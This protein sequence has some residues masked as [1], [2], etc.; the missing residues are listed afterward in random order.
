MRAGVTSMPFAAKR[1]KVSALGCAISTP[2]IASGSTTMMAPPAVV[3]TTATLRRPRADRADRRAAH[4]RQRFEQGFEAFH[5]RDAAIGEERA[6]DV[7]LAGE[8]AGVRDGELAR[9]RRAAELVGDDRLAARR[10]A[11]REFAQ[12]RP[13]CGCFRGTADSCRCRGHRASRRKSRR[14]R[15]RPRCRSTRG[16]QSRCRAPCRATSARR[17]WCR[18]A[19]QRRCGRP[20]CPARRRPRWR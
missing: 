2:R 10:G 5:P 1:A 18:S 11:E 4:Q 16:P 20:G 17:S 8:R 6:R 3:V 15:D 14:S 19:R 13:R 7:V 9:R 12:A